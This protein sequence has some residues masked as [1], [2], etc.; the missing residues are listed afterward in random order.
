MR[1]AASVI[2]RVLLSPREHFGGSWCWPSAVS[3]CHQH[4]MAR[5]VAVCVVIQRG[6]VRSS[7]VPGTGETGSIRHQVCVQLVCHKGRKK[8]HCEQHLLL[9]RKAVTNLDSIFRSRDVTLPTM[10][11]LVKAMAFPVVM[12]GCESWTVNGAPPT[13]GHPSPQ[14]TVWVSPCPQCP[15]PL[16]PSAFSFSL[17]P[18]ACASGD[19]LPGE[20]RPAVP[21]P[22]VCLAPL[23]GPCLPRPSRLLQGGPLSGS[24]GV[25][26]R[27]VTRVPQ[28][29]QSR[30]SHR[31]H[32]PSNVRA[33]QLCR[34]PGPKM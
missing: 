26:A 6:C 5:T 21:V 28:A 25:S 11:C 20:L 2:F 8:V 14:Q 4:T 10:V 3:G 17:N 33:E 18:Q 7:C 31:P 29:D 19:T 27:V 23:K 16:L 15:R 1:V 32:L 12:Y 30:C 22:P 9:G 24:P 34:G 13:S